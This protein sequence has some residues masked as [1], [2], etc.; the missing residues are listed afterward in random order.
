VIIR[1]AADQQWNLNI[2][3]EGADFTVSRG[4]AERMNS[5]ARV[6]LGLNSLLKTQLVKKKNDHEG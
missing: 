2:L 4:I 6:P 1:A 3:P 5:L